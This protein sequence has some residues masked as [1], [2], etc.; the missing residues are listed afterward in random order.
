MIINLINQR[1]DTFIYSVKYAPSPKHQMLDVMCD[2]L[3]GLITQIYCL[4]LQINT[5]YK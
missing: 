1:R 2:N 4:D 3:D 5:F